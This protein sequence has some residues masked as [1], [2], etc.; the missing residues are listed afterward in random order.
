MPKAKA[1]QSS[2]GKGK[3][4]AGESRCEEAKMKN[5][6]SDISNFLADPTFYQPAQVKILLGVGAWAQLMQENMRRL[7]SGFVAQETRLGWLLFGEPPTNSHVVGINIADGDSTKFDEHLEQLVRNLFEAEILAGD[8]SNWTEEQQECETHFL[9]THTF[10]LQQKRYVVQLP[11]RRDW[12]RIGSNRVTALQRYL[13]LE[14]RFRREP[15]L[16]EKYKA[17]VNEYIAKD[18]L[19][20]ATRP[21]EGK[22]YYIPHHAILKKFRVVFDASC[23]T[24]TGV[25]LNDVQMIGPKLQRDLIDLLWGFRL[26]AYGISADI[27]QMFPQVKISPRN[28]DLQRI[29]WR[30]HTEKIREYWLTRVTFGMASA[31]FCAVRAM[32]QC[33]RDNAVKW[34]Q[35]AEVVLNNFYMDDCLSG[36]DTEEELLSLCKQ[37]QQILVAGG[38][39]LCKW[40]SNSNHVQRSL[41]L[42]SN[43][44]D[45]W[46]N[47]YNEA[48]VLGLKWI[49]ST[50]ELSFAVK[51]LTDV[52]PD[53]WT[54]RMVLS[55][56]AR[57]FDP[58]GLA[59]PFIIKA[60]ILLQNI[61]QEKLGWDAILPEPI[62]TMW[63]KIFS[64]IHQ[65]NSVR[66]PRW[67]GFSRRLDIALHGFA[68]AS[69]QAFGAAIY[70]V[71]YDNEL[72]TSNLLLAKSRVAPLKKETIPRLELRAATL[73]GELMQR[74]MTIGETHHKIKIHSAYCWS[75]SMVVLCWLKRDSASLKQFVANRVL[76]IKRN[77]TTC[78]WRYVTTDAN[79]ADPISRGVSMDE[80]INS[81]LWWKGP[82]FL[83]LPEAMW[84]KTPDE[85]H[86]EVRTSVN[87]EC[88]VRVSRESRGAGYQPM[89]GISVVVIKDQSLLYRYSSFT[90]VIRV[91]A[92]VFRF[93]RNC[94]A[95]SETRRKSYLE[96]SE[97]EGALAIWIKQEQRDHFGDDIRQM[98]HIGQGVGNS[99]GLRL[100]NAIEALT[101]FLRDGILRM[102]GRLQEA[103]LPDCQRNPAIL[104]GKGRLAWLIA[105]STHLQ[106]LHCGAQQL[107]AALR[108]KYWIIG[109]RTLSRSL[110]KHCV[111]CERLK[112]KTCEQMMGNLPACR[113]RP[114]RPFLHSG[115]DYA[116]PIQVRPDRRRGNV[117]LK[118]Y[119]AVFV[120]MVSKAVH[121]EFVSD[122]STNAFLMAFIRFTSRYGHCL[123]LW[124]DNGT[125]FVG[126]E[127]E[128]S[129]MLQT[130]RGSDL[131]EQLSTRQTEWH[132]ITPSAPHQ[133]GLWE[134][135]VKATKYHLRRVM[136]ARL[137]T[138][139]AMQ[140]L[141]A[142]IG[143]VLNSRPLCAQSADPQDLN[144]LTPG[145]LLIG[146]AL[147]PA[148]GEQIP[149]ERP[150]NRLSYWQSRQLITQR[151]WKLWSDSYLHEL[152]QRPKWREARQNM[153]V[154][155]LVVIK[156]EV[157]PP[158]LWKMGRV[159]ALHPGSD[160]L[161]RNVTIWTGQNTISRPVQKLCI[162]PIEPVEPRAVSSLKAG[163][164]SS[165]SM[166]Y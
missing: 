89:V 144:P 101:P 44:N 8:E 51:S 57:I 29:F 32:Q 121:L 141:L 20:L 117:V 73:L 109:M 53:S 136:G 50:D 87:N 108:Q 161:V 27:K 38:F 55:I 24:D 99:K 49:P 2:A 103:D 163:G 58:D 12:D 18:W 52:D 56:T 116:G 54:K 84:P 107:T 119:I 83:R 10:E 7:S 30:D 48:S 127:R 113:V 140:T 45:H 139:E 40:R 36:A 135:A 137:L 3:K 94:R 41:N 153:K 96:I 19:M 79:P 143:A 1:M 75:D 60:K 5:L 157:T 100:S 124:S 22:A 35:A 131:F 159:T 66:V 146:E 123:H 97:L 31:P 134:A 11:L 59:S 67:I 102:R 104:P 165:E 21:P 98:E 111:K 61:W 62:K 95:P 46:F 6:P 77:T 166:S 88:R 37:L 118:G 92:W 82:E 85:V 133:G 34:P 112:A 142:E 145:H 154:G 120:C 91:T 47:T 43:D 151:F 63:Q 17:F 138:I 105:H 42:E 129:R 33:A 93:V 130:W 68:D 147:V 15:E 9:E 76:Q 162:L 122:L 74:V 150:E 65:F 16:K 70:A 23:S 13:R 115:V 28:W 126:A 14:Q 4:R 155:D 128:L 86:E 71:I 64:Q 110:I 90:R 125:N 25:S 81:E 114:A 69:I 160:G 152:Q 156:N 39:E 26:Y 148:L 72:V 132:F 80:L 78:K 106:L 158:T 164:C 149:V